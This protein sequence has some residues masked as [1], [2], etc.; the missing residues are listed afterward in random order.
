METSEQDGQAITINTQYL[1]QIHVY[2]EFI[3]HEYFTQLIGNQGIA[4]DCKIADIR[5]RA[6]IELLRAPMHP[7]GD[8]MVNACQHRF[9]NAF[10]GYKVCI[11]SY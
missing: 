6:N 4:L 10:S 8:L 3:K 2:I 9:I 5:Q 7:W 1:P 11:L